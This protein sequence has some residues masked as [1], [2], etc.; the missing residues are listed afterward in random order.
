MQNIIN[1]L[2]SYITANTTLI[3]SPLY[4]DMIPTSE[5]DAVMIRANPGQPVEN[6]Y[7]SGSRCGQFPFSLFA[8]S[9]NSETAYNQLC[10]LIPILD[11][12]EVQ[13]TD[14]TQVTIVPTSNPSLVQKIEAGDY[15]YTAGFRLDYFTRG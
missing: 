3:A 5:G 6:R 13:L 7:M 1:D 15:I 2:A 11:L 12:D 10:S 8:R 14:E 9:P 4:I